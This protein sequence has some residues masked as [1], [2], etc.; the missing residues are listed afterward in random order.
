MVPRDP[1]IGLPRI[2]TDHQPMPRIVKLSLRQR[3]EAIENRLLRVPRSVGREEA[4][5]G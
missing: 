3:H 4:S 2:V 1:R 5:A